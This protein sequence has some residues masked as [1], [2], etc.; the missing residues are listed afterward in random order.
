MAN[1]QQGEPMLE[2]F[3]SAPKTLLE[4]IEAGCATEPSQGKFRPPDKLLALLKAKSQILMESK[5]GVMPWRSKPHCRP[6][7]H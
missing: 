4:A 5:K 6:T 7:H 1:T 2:K 3:L